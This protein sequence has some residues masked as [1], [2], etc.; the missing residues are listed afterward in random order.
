V[1]LAGIQFLV[2]VV[3]VPPP[4][5]SPVLLVVSLVVIMEVVVVAGLKLITLAAQA[6]VQ[7]Q[8][9]LSSSKNF[10]D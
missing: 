7:A 3:P 9:G 6:A 4:L 5:L 8:V 10:I 1:V 2:P